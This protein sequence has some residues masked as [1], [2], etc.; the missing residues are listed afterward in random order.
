MK[1]KRSA[2]GTFLG[3]CRYRWRQRHFS[4]FKKLGIPGPEPNLI[5]GNLLE[6]HA[7]EHY[8]VLGRWMEKYGSVVGFFNGDVPFVL[9]HD[10]DFIEHVYVRNF[11]NFTDRGLTMMTDQMHP[12]LGKSVI[13]ARGAKWRN[14]RRC[15]SY[16]FSSAKL[17]KM[18]AGFE[19]DMDIFLKSLE[20]N[21]ET[22]EEV[23]M[24]LKCEQLTMDYVVRG[25]F[26]IEER[27]QGKPHHPFLSATK[28]AASK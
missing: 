22:G 20:T 4:Y 18:L 5:W 10:L 6:Y 9:L 19:E 11:T 12:T 13:H 16:A 28:E 17:K 26:G 7:S 23:D 1:F 15:I 14:I 25:S 2:Q 3:F 8:K 27:F 24:M 21:A